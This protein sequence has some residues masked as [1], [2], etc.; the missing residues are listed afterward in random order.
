MCFV[1]EIFFEFFFPLFDRAKKAH[2]LVVFNR[3]FGTQQ[4]NSMKYLS[5]H[6]MWMIYLYLNSF[7]VISFTRKK[8]TKTKNWPI[9]QRDR[10]GSIDYTFSG[11][12]WWSLRAAE[13]TWILNTHTHTNCNVNELTICFALEGCLPST[14]SLLHRTPHSFCTSTCIV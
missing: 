13:F 5:E 2:E 10:A 1:N 4:T 9:R 8:K 3:F 11:I 6:W 7:I 12:Y 14:I